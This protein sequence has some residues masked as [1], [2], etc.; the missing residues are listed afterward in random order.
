MDW[1][2]Y[3]HCISCGKIITFETCDAGHFVPKSAG[4]WFRW[5][6]KNIHAQCPDCNRF[7]SNDTG[8]NFYKNLCVKIGQEETDNLLELKLK[9]KQKETRKLNEIKDYYKHKLET[10]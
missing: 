4:D 7:G 3:G 6:E 2:G 9:G 1:R 5:N 10:L 8:A